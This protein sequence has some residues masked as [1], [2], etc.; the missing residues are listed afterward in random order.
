M[1]AALASNGWI[2]TSCWAG[3]PQ[4]TFHQ[5]GMGETI[6]YCVRATQNNINNSYYFAG[7]TNRGIHTSLLGDPTLRMHIVRPVNSLKSV[8]MANKSVLLSWKLCQR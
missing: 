3:R 5:M 8:I 2:L 1:R 6:G 4:Y 7:L